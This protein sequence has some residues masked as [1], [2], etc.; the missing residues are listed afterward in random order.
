[1]KRAAILLF[2]LAASCMY[3][4]VLVERH[5]GDVLSGG[6]RPGKVNPVPAT[7]PARA[8]GAQPCAE[9]ARTRCAVDTCKGTNMDSVTLA[10]AGGEVQR[11]VVNMECTAD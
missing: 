4:P 2:V 5:P 3:K 11:C 10:C 8:R 1:M 9:V 6:S 7:M